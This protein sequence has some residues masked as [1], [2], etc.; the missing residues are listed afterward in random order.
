[1]RDAVT[2][3]YL[4]AIAAAKGFATG[5]V[6]DPD[7]FGPSD[8]LFHSSFLE[9][10]FSSEKRRI[11]SVSAL[12]PRLVCFL[13][14]ELRRDWNTRMASAVKKL[15]PKIRILLISLSTINHQW[16]DRL[17]TL[18]EVEGLSTNNP[19]DYLLSGEPEHV[20]E[21]FLSACG[22]GKAGSRVFESPG[23]AD[24]DAL[25]MPDKTLFVSHVNFGDSYLIY[26][27]KGCPYSCS[28]CE[29]TICR[30]TFGPGYFRRRGVSNVIAE[31]E[32]AV[33][34]FGSKEIIFKDSVFTY[35]RE[36]LKAF[37]VIY[38]ERI[39]VPFKCFAKADVFDTGTAEL[40]KDSGCYCVEFGVQTFN[41]K[42]KKEILKREERREVFEKACRVCDS[43]GLRYDIDHMFGIPGESAEDH[44]TAAVFYSGL[45]YLNRIKCHNLV[46]YERAEIS[47][48]AAGEEKTGPRDFFS[49]VSGAGEMQRINSAFQKFFKVLPVL[50]VPLR[51]FFSSGN[52][53]LFFRFI[54]GLLI[55]SG[56]L[57]IALRSGDLR[58]GIYL[59]YYPLKIRSAL[60]AGN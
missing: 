46:F 3:E 22:S 18:S 14:N 51:R 6:Y 57:V 38:K 5:L 42:I 58:F 60:G 33:R 24:L 29:E 39:G 9:K 23:L 44:R 30:N 4:S 53:A 19:F 48:I 32:E 21:K 25:P 45:R 49:G 36:W 20:F 35:D 8:N 12:K 10:L 17:T 52:N 34:K 37:L 27:S 11:A 41:E 59:K 1:V 31:L 40:L 16:F 7:L 56:Q 2:L 54:P 28:Y 26:T 43:L 47:G 15:N 55:L 50:P 13:D